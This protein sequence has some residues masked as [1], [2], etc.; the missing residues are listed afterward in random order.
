VVGRPVVPRLSVA[1]TSKLWRPSPS[2][3]Y[4]CPVEQPANALESRLHSNVLPS[5]F[6]VNVNCA[7]RLFVGSGG[8]LSMVTTGPA[9]SI[10]QEADAAELVFPAASI[11]RTSK[12]WGPSASEE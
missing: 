8:P 9:V 12:L 5:L 11:A 10:V 4:A 7:S 6:D 2:P 1:L 3:E